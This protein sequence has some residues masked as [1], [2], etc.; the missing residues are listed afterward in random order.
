MRTTH[1]MHCLT[2]R[3]SYEAG[4]TKDKDDQDNDMSTTTHH[5]TAPTTPNHTTTCA[6][7]IQQKNTKTHTHT[8]S[9]AHV[10]VHARDMCMYTHVKCTCSCMCMCICTCMCMCMCVFV[11]VGVRIFHGKTQ[12]TMVESSLPT[13]SVDGSHKAGENFKKKI[14]QPRSKTA[15]V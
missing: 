9:H 7:D 13:N 10:Y 2:R 11:H 6:H 12:S 14:I 3:S 4:R 15:T 1:S 8:H 5:T